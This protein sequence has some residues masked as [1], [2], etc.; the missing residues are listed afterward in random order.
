[1]KSP[2]LEPLFSCDSIAQRVQDLSRQ[3]SYDYAHSRPVLVGILKGAF[4]FMSDLVRHLNVDA[5]ID[6]IQV[7]SYGSSMASS[8]SCLLKKELNVPVSGRHVLIVE[9]IID[10]GH[11]VAYLK[12]HFLQHNPKSLKVCCLID[13]HAGRIHDHLID[14]AAFTIADGFVVGYGLDFNEQFRCLSAIYKVVSS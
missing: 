11:T 8:G 14:Y 13:K 4:I 1:M 7:A 6:F 12:Q 9:D 10:T 2:T 3:I 5:D